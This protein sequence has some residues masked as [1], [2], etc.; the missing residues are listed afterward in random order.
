LEALLNKNSIQTLKGIDESTVFHLKSNGEDPEETKIT[1][2]LILCKCDYK[3]ICLSMLTRYK[4]KNFFG[5]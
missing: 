5:E 3:P 2:P 4:K 1:S